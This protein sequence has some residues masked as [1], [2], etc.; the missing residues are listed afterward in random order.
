MAI[1]S[2]TKGTLYHMHLYFL[3][4]A[5]RKKWQNLFTNDEK[6]YYSKFKKDHGNT[7]EFM[8]IDILLNIINKIEELPK[9]IDEN[10]NDDV[11]KELVTILEYIISK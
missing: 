4:L 10:T 2:M 7:P 5:K 6:E 3:D 11:I 8:E 9:E 1:D